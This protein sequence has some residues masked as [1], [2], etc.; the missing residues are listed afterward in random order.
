MDYERFILSRRVR[1]SSAQDQGARNCHF[2]HTGAGMLNRV[3]PTGWEEKSL[4]LP[5]LRTSFHI[6]M[7]SRHDAI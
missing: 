3:C 2:L 7:F 4:R 1:Q 5:R 6:F